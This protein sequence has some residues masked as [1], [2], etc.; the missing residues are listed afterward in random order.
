M[1]KFK[2]LQNLAYKLRLLILKIHTFNYLSAISMVL[3]SNNFIT[4]DCTGDTE[5]SPRKFPAG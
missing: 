5:K 4:A 1:R 2:E 3:V